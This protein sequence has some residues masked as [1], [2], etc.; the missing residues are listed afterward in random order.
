MGQMQSDQPLLV[1]E[2]E[3]VLP[4]RCACVY[5]RLT[6]L[7]FDSMPNGAGVNLFVFVLNIKICSAKSVCK[8]TKSCVN[9]WI[10]L[11]RCQD[12]NHVKQCQ[13]QN[14]NCSCDHKYNY[15]TNAIA[16]ATLLML[17]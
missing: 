16:A 3:L 6:T 12:L 14:H 10:E 5:T 9:P 2:T 15:N 4:L 17:F 11:S 7:L 8:I 13:N 1:V